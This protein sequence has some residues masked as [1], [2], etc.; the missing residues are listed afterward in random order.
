MAELRVCVGHLWLEIFVMKDLYAVCM[1]NPYCC[2]MGVWFENC[3][4]P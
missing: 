1:V 2:S 3:I 4:S